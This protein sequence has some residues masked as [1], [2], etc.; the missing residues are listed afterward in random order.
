[1]EGGFVASAIEDYGED[2]AMLT[3]IL[4]VD[5]DATI[6]LLLRRLLEKHPS[7]Q[8]CGD[9]S[10]GAEAIQ[11]I[12]HLDPDVVVMDL[13]MP[14]M[15]GLQAASEIVETHPR[16]PHAANQRPRSFQATGVGGAPSWIQWRCNQEQR[17]RSC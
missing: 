4:I 3:R 15:T 14:I 13:S 7:W 6:R 17:S 16:L 5:D 8:V 1:V 11:T 2:Y 12:D 9:A 10:N